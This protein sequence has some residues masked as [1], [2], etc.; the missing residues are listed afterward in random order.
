MALG[1][2]YATA[3]EYRAQ[4]VTVANSDDAVIERAL[5]AATRLIDRATGHGLGFQKDASGVSRYYIGNG[6]RILDIDDH[7]SIS[8]VAYDSARNDGYATT[9]AAADYEKLPLNAATRPEAEPYRQLRATEW[10]A[11]GIW[12]SGTKI[13][14]TGVGGWAAVPASVKACCIELAALFLV[15]SPRATSEVNEMGAT[16]LRTSREGQAIIGEM[17]RSYIHPRAIL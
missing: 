4:R 13:R 6:H 10:G 1:D 14:V 5:D 17:L 7:V 8:A 3:T 2:R 15:Q 12:P 11:L 16:T 9:L